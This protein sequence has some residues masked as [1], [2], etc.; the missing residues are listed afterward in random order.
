[1]RYLVIKLIRFYQVMIS[2]LLGKNCIFYPTCSHYMVEAIEKHGVR[3]GGWLGIKRLLRCHP[4]YKGKLID[5][6]P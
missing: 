4:F 6:V 5:P 3:R 2:P 1:M